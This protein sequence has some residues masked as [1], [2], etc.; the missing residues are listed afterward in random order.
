MIY[1]TIMMTIMYYDII[2][3]I[4]ILFLVHMNEKTHMNYPLVDIFI[5]DLG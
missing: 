1:L 5:T 3:T 2:M 4:D